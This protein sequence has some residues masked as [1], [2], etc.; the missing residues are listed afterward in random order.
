MLTIENLNINDIDEMFYAYIIEHKK[1]DY[2]LMKCEFIL[3]FNDNQFFHY[4]ASVLYSNKTM[5]S[6]YK[7]LEN[8]ISDLRKRYNFNHIAEKYTITIVNKLDMTYDLYIK[9]KMHAFERKLNAM[10]NKNKY[11]FN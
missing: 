5:C 6:W 11:L 10:I 8:I 1:Y 7:L 9:H 2:Y 4:V 3:V